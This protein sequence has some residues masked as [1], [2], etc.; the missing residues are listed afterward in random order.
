[1]SIGLLFM[2]CHIL[3]GLIVAV[4]PGLPYLAYAE[5][6]EEKGLAIANEGDRRD[7]GFADSSVKLEMILSNRHGESSTRELRMKT[8]EIMDPTLGDKSLTVFD[9]PRDIKGSAFLSFTRI[10]EPDEQWLYL[11]AFE[12]GL[13]GFLQQTNRV[14]SWVV[15]FPMRT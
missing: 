7:Q 10:K 15:S 9:H 6:P 5:S 3:A 4:A 11:P 1:M 8:L 14:L 12:N 2:R 13:S